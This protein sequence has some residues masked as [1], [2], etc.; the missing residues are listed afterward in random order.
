MAFSDYSD[1]SDPCFLKARAVNS[2]TPLTSGFSPIKLFPNNCPH[3]E[4]L[5]V[6]VKTSFD[7]I[8]CIFDKYGPI[9]RIF[10]DYSK[11]FY[12]SL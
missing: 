10:M 2:T 3:L 7:E 11:C 4:I 6:P 9:V 5:K 1:S 12:F 8:R